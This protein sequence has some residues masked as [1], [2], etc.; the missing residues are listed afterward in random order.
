MVVG[1]VEGMD[2]SDGAGGGGRRKREEE[3]GREGGGDDLTEATVARRG[4]Y[5]WRAC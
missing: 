3:R 1:S 2:K 5:D 4:K